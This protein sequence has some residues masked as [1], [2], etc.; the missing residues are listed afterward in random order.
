MYLATEAK[1]PP[2][3]CP[4]MQAVI[5]KPGNMPA[6]PNSP[7]WNIAPQPD[8][9]IYYF[10]IVYYTTILWLNFEYLL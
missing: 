9:I 2:S 6:R 5:Q 3:A 7:P 1:M 4:D 10:Y 8:R